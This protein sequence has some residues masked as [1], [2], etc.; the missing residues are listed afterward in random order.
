LPIRNGTRRTG[1]INKEKYL[2][3]A[4]LLLTPSNHWRYTKGDIKFHDFFKLF[5]KTEQELTILL[6]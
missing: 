1:S 2:G 5:L 4:D 6:Y 3:A